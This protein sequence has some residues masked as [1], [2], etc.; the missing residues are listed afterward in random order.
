MAEAV[1]AVPSKSPKGAQPTTSNTYLK[2]EWRT[3]MQNQRTQSNSEYR[4]LTLDAFEAGREKVMR[5]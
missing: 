5:S 3:C 2:E 4:N 1:E